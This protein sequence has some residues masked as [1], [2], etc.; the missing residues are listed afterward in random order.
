MLDSDAL[1]LRLALVAE[2]LLARSALARVLADQDEALTVLASG[3]LAEVE[4]I[5][6]TSPLDA[7][8]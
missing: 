5:A 3:T 4:S 2:D 1:P 6:L 8:L 7:V